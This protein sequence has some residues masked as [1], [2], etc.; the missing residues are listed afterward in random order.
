MADEEKPSDCVKVAI[1]LRPPSTKEV[2][3]GEK[4]IVDVEASHGDQPGSVTITDPDEKDKPAQFAFDIVFGLE[5]EQSQ[6]YD[7]IGLPALQQTLKGYNGTIF[8]YGQTGSGKSWCM[9]G[10]PGDL[11]GIIPR[12]NEGLFVQIAELQE[13]IGTRKFLVMCTF[14]EIYNEII[15]DLLNPVQDR[16]KVGGGL[17]VKEHPVLG[18][19]VKDLQ[20]MV[21]DGADKLETLM[22]TG[23]KNRAVSSTNMNSVSSRSHSIFTIKVHQK[24]DVDQS[25]NVFAKLNLVDLAGSERQ[26]GTGATG[27][28][29]KEGANINKSLS[30]LGNVINALVENANGK[31]VFVPFRNSKLTRVLQES[32]GGNSL[33]TM[34][35]TLSPAA[36]N[37]EETVGTLRYANRAKAI[38]VSA[39]KNEEA[40]QISRLNAEIEELKKKLAGG[41]G[42]GGDMGG[43]LLAEDEK[44]EIEEKYKQQLKDMEAMASHNWEE[45]T[46]M[47][48]E[49]EG[50]LQRA[51]EEQ[52]RHARAMEEEYRKRFRLLQEQDDLEFT[53]R[54]LLDTVQSLPCT[55][56]SENA[57]EGTGGGAVPLLPMACAPLR[58]GELPRVWIKSATAIKEVADG[59]KQQRTMALVFQGAFSEDLRLWVDA[60]EASDRVLARAGARRSLA[61]LDTLRRECGKLCEFE[62]QGRSRASDFAA[63]VS[64]V[65]AAWTA[66]GAPGALAELRAQR[67][68]EGKDAEKSSTAPAEES[69]DLPPMYTQA[70]DDI[71][72]ILQLIEQQARARAGEFASLAALEVQSVA[73]LTVRGMNFVMPG[74]SEYAADL[75]LIGNSCPVVEPEVADSEVAA[76]AP[77]RPREERAL[78]EWQAEDADG[79]LEAVDSA[80]TQIVDMETLKGKRTPQELLSRPPP[81]FVHDVALLIRQSTG[82]LPTLAEEWPDGREAKL[83][84]LQYIADAVAASLGLAAGGID[85]DPA[86]VLKGKEVPHTLRLL[87]LLAIAA[88]REHSQPNGGQA[89]SSRAQRDRRR[90]GLVPPTDLPDLLMAVVRCL[91]GVVKKQQQEQERPGTGHASPTRELESNHRAM[92]ERLEEATQIRLKHEERLKALRQ[93]LA[94][95]QSALGERTVQLTAAHSHASEATSRKDQVRMQI[96]ELRAGLLQRAQEC[97]FETSNEGAAN[98]RRELEELAATLKD[99]SAERV[100]LAAEVQSLQQQRIDLDSYKENMDMELNRMKLRAAEDLA[101]L[102]GDPT[103]AEEIMMLQAEKQKWDVKVLALEEKMRAI[104]KFDDD[105]RQQE[106]RI[107]EDRRVHSSEQ[108]EMQMQL[109]V[110]TEERDALREG[111]DQLWQDKARTLDELDNVTNGYS[112]LS[113]RLIEKSIEANETAQQLEQYEQAL[114]MLQEN[115]EQLRQSPPPRVHSPGLAVAPTP[116]PAPPLAATNGTA[117][118]M[119]PRAPGPLPPL[120][121]G[122]PP[123]TTAPPAGG[124]D[125]A[126]SSHY[127][128]DDFEEPD[129]D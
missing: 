114:A 72:R 36:C 55:S 110:L 47:S 13:A 59:L 28:T 41:G 4:C 128:D 70:I 10:G 58:T 64:E 63:A 30:A 99:R 32:L 129:E 44:R 73:E 14:F 76:T 33:C 29:L 8:A 25:R 105:E 125:D 87:Q 95:T 34:L 56:V 79:S 61:K 53:I 31:K 90:E 67:N 2:N 107:M 89:A 21:V 106:D 3:A 57:S 97:E 92:Q 37:Y 52:R 22:N 75:A 69:D 112:H 111:M 60:E 65:S 88:A 15:Y 48:K 80:L 86:D 16:S 117:P 109:Q 94:A 119:V 38:K 45:K 120:P 50:Q 18:I 1:R 11:K 122:P 5:T 103:D 7:N 123:P 68:D 46:R 12:V 118:P 108:D 104:G 98:L 20:E 85:F 9:L 121:P 101:P 24:D 81:K 84:L 78:H 49:H 93:E 74:A 100:R 35:A 126:G 23:I 19:Y 40:S 27:Q 96:E 66:Q 6:V 39:T 77:L 62:T 124:G 115:M 71:G 116:S 102:G 43:G 91:Q 17:Q 42:G 26:K 127:S 51:L 113:D 83:D 82:F 54:G